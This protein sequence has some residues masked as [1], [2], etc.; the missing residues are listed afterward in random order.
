MLQALPFFIPRGIL[1]P[2]LHNQE[3]SV[4]QVAME[5][6]NKTSLSP[7]DMFPRPEPMGAGTCGRPWKRVGPQK[8]IPHPPWKQKSVL[9]TSSGVSLRF[10]GPTNR[11]VRFEF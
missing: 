3:I 1:S 4:R 11:Q 6:P 5:I 9:L 2:L 7:W 10:R 8:M